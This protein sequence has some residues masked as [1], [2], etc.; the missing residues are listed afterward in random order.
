[1]EKNTKALQGCPDVQ[2]VAFPEVTK[3]EHFCNIKL[4][5][6]LIS[7]MVTSRKNGEK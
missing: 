6:H 5:K 4:Q 7:K 2:R 1:M 3:I